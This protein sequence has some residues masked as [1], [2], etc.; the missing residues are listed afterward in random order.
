MT[1][2]FLKFWGGAAQAIAKDIG[3]EQSVFYFTN[4]QERDALVERIEKHAALGLVM[5]TLEGHMTH[6]D[7]VAICT[8][9]FRGQTYVYGYNFGPE[10]AP[11]S[12]EFMFECGNYSCDCNRSTF[13]REGGHQE[14]PTLDC[15]NEIKMTNLE[16]V[17]Q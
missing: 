6:K 11:S 14:V 2:Y 1:E 15:G 12:A 9:L 7:T 8:F 13:L 16:V 4:K 3:T 5:V 17:F 10:Y